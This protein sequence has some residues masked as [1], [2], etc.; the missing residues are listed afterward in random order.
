MSATF[1]VGGALANKPRNGGEAW[2]RMSWVVGL[3][4]LGADVVFIEEIAHSQC[5]DD[6]GRPSDPQGSANVAWFTDVVRRFGLTGSAALICGDR[7]IAGLSM[8]DLIDRTDGAPLLVN[9]SG[10]LTAKRVLRTFRTR[11]FVDIDPCFTQLWQLGGLAGARLA[12]HD[13]FFTIGE[14][15]GERD[16]AVPP[17]GI[18]WMRT[19]QPVVL[20]DWAVPVCGGQRFTTVATWRG[21]Y[22]PPSHDGRAYR[23]K[24]HE[25]RRFAGIAGRTRERLELA[26][27]IEPEDRADWNLLVTNGWSVVD[28]RPL[29][30]TPDAFAEYVGGSKAE[31]SCAQG[32]YVQS[33]S[34]WFSDRTTRYLACGLPAVVQDT[35]FSRFL[36]VGEGLLSFTTMD[37]AVR[38]VESVAADY[39]RHRKAARAVAEEEFDSDKVLARFL[40]IVGVAP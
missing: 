1:A 4:R 19:R 13:V 39:E 30:N 28:A 37:E 16:C 35:G 23:L 8:S 29:T 32:A 40:E 26:L 14:R 33:A 10:H 17:A 20:E 12:G 7:S 25:F 24:A 36:P 31:F 6:Q 3:R 11:A 22:G 5:R 2:V 21:P 18:R 27:A 15:I 9:I 34:G 38:A